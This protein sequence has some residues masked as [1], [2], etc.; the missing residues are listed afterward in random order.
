MKTVTINKIGL[1]LGSGSSRGWAHIGAIEALQ[2]AGIPIHLIS[3]CSVGAF[4]GAVFASGGLDQLK[5]YVIE[6]DGE[7]L[8][9]L[10]DLALL[11]PGLLDGDKTL[12]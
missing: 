3:G 5:K 10:S 4:I 8:F 6:M 9:S 11:R 1:V 2:D 7:S 12:R